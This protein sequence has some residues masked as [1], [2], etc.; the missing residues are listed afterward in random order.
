MRCLT[1]LGIVKESNARISRATQRGVKN[2]LC[3]TLFPRLKGKKNNN[4]Y[5][6][7]LSLC[8]EEPVG[9]AE[10]HG[11]EGMTWIYIWNVAVWLI[12]PLTLW[13]VTR[14]LWQTEWTLLLALNVSSILLLGPRWGIDS[15][16]TH[17]KEQ[18]LTALLPMAQNDA[19]CGDFFVLVVFQPISAMRCFSELPLCFKISAEWRNVSEMRRWPCSQMYKGRVLFVPLA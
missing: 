17:T 13:R 9:E 18:R 11:Y 10:E 19:I 15:M 8:V 6:G 5:G 4:K 2:C 14:C 1:F 16:V 3:C 12:L 7:L